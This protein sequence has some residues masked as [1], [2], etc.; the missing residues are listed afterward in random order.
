[1]IVY[2]VS[3][4]VSVIE[5]VVQFYQKFSHIEIVVIDLAF[6]V[7]G[8]WEVLKPTREI[9]SV[10]WLRVVF[11]KKVE[12]GICISTEEE[13]FNVEKWKSEALL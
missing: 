11:D 6:G 12:I 4:L 13:K 3:C 1:M 7:C 2:N 8:N 10:V 9:H 5:V